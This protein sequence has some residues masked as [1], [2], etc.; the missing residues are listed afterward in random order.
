MNIPHQVPTFNVKKLGLLAMTP[1]ALV[2][3]GLVLWIPVN[4]E[5]KK[6]SEPE[7]KEELQAIG[8]IIPI[9]PTPSSTSNVSASIA[10]TPSATI[11]APISMVNPSTIERVIQSESP[12]IASRAKAS[13]PLRQAPTFV[14]PT[15]PVQSI[16]PVQPTAPIIPEVITPEGNLGKVLNGIPCPG[17]SKCSRVAH[18]QSVVLATLAKQYG[19]LPKEVTDI[20]L[21]KDGERP[22]ESTVIAYQVED[23]VAKEFLYFILPLVMGN[24]VDVTFIDKQKVVALGG[25]L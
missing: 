21:P 10:P 5:T 14:K 19:N 17:S 24:K 11:P 7:K 1:I 23:K 22:A 18:P 2:I 3:H 16:A 9:L 12:S 6:E 25:V 15:T 8:D 20:A 13:E 4:T